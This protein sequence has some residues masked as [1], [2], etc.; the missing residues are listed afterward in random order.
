MEPQLS[1]AQTGLRPPH[2]SAARPFRVRLAARLCST[3][4]DRA[5]AAGVEPDAAPQL[6]ARAELLRSRRDAALD[7]DLDEIG[8]IAA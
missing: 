2:Q 7:L 1:D 4:L 8:D 5:L 3:R 6:A